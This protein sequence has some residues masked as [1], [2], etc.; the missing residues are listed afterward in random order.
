MRGLRQICRPCPQ[1]EAHAAAGELRLPEGDERQ[2][3]P[4]LSRFPGRRA[5]HDG[6]RGRGRLELYGPADHQGAPLCRAQGAQRIGR[7]D[8]CRATADH[9]FGQRCPVVAC[10]GRD[11]GVCREGRDPVLHDP[12]G[13]RRRPGRPSL[14]LPDDAQRRVPRGRSDHHPRHAHEL[15]DRPRLAAALQRRPQRSRASRST[16]RRWATRRAT[17]TFPSSATAS[18][19]CSNCARR[20]MRRPPTASSRGAR[21]SPTARRRSASRAGGNY[22]TDGDIHP[23]RLCEEIKNFMQREAILV[24]RRA[25]DPQF[26]PPVDPDLRPRAPAQ[27]RPLR[28]DGRR[29]ALR[30][31]RQGRQARCAGHLP[32]WRRLLRAER[33]GARH[34][35]AAQIAVA[36]RDQPQRRLDRRPRTATSPAATSATRATTRWPRPWAATPNMSRTPEDIRP[37]LQRAWKKV[38]EGMVGFV[39]VKTDYRARATTVRFSSRET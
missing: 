21:S 18:R 7:R 19:C 28:H 23:L 26:R 6:R 27:F 32:A 24:G 11:E 5:V 20:S 36:V 38:E 1:P 14:F 8:R 17:S 10:L 12:A 22:P 25:G 13:P 29:T 9:R 37:A 15:C 34:R 4:G 30:G 16:P 39:N 2:A 3:R 35:G 31:R 33:D